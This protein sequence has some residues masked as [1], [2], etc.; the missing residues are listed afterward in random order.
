MLRTQC[1]FSVR[2]VLI[3]DLAWVAF[4]IWEWLDPALDVVLL[5]KELRELWK[6]H[7]YGH[8]EEDST[9]QQQDSWVK[10]YLWILSVEI[11]FKSSVLLSGMKIGG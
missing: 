5:A 8:K 1:G 2:S 3:W 11:A 9:E 4:T 6:N 7:L 10:P